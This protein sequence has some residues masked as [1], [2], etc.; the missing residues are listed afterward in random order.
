MVKHDV[1]L[2]HGKIKVIEI[3]HGSM[4]SMQYIVI[5]ALPSW[6][7]ALSSHGVHDHH[8]YVV[9]TL[10]IQPTLLVGSLVVVR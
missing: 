2:Q 9:R 7:L 10:I 1:K 6:N 5:M 3:R 8:Y 4:V